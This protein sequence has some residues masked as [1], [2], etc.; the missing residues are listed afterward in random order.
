M[1]DINLQSHYNTND[2]CEYPVRLNQQEW[3][4][5]EWTVQLMAIQD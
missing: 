2:F 5:D 3:L 1:K 4:N